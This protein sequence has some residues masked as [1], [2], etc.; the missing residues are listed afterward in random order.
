VARYAAA[1]TVGDPAVAS[2]GWG[3]GALALTSEA[4]FRALVR[5]LVPVDAG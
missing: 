5:R 4:G 1:V 2:S 3:V